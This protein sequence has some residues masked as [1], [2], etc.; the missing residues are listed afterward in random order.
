LGTYGIVYDGTTEDGT[1]VAIK[2]NLAEDSTS[3]ISSIREADLLNHLQGHP[4]IIKLIDV[5]RANPFNAG[6]HL[7][8]LDDEKYREDHKNQRNDDIHFVFAKGTY[9]LKTYIEALTPSGNGYAY[10]TNFFLLKKFMVQILLGVEYCHRMKIIHRDLKPSNIVVNENLDKEFGETNVVKIIDFGLAKPFSYQE[11]ST[12]YTVTTLYRA[13]E[14]CLGRESYDYRA[15]VWSIGCIFYELIARRPFLSADFLDF[16]GEDDRKKENTYLLSLIL[17]RLPH[18]LSTSEFTYLV[19]KYRLKLT[20]EATPAVRLTFQEQFNFSNRKKTLFE[21]G[22]GETLDT[23]CDLLEE[24][25]AFDLGERSTVEECLA[26][27]FFG[28]DQDYIEEVRTRYPVPQFDQIIR[29]VDCIERRW[30]GE[31]F[32]WF[33]DLYQKYI[34]AYEEKNHHLVKKLDDQIYWYT[35]RKLFQA[36][37]IYDRYLYLTFQTTEIPKNALESKYAGKLFE[38]TNNEVR[39]LTCLYMTIKYFS[40][41]EKVDPI[42]LLFP[43]VFKDHPENMAMA[44]NLEKNMLQDG[45]QYRIYRPTLFEEIDSFEDDL[46]NSQI[47]RLLT[48]YLVNPS[49]SGYTTREVYAYFREYLLGPNESE[50]E[51]KRSNKT[52]DPDLKRPIDPVLLGKL[53][54]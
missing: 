28:P 35:P 27:P 18:P 5:V 1:N 34:D 12:P 4:F 38:K 37:D 6:G 44:K 13:P 15:D 16:S 29:V 31:I 20:P 32:F 9:S 36:A 22:T 49:I 11:N 46:S 7:T 51:G 41:I 21:E 52:V 53:K 19:K 39:V 42:D 30:M 24:M 50:K 14:I 25:L 43:T 17:G 40:S 23:F 48:F 8:P 54:P 2:R 3:F 10:P 45:F 33:T 47:D 26:H